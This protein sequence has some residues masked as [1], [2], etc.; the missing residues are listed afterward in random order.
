METFDEVAQ[1]PSGRA[2]RVVR[3]PARTGHRD[4]G[5][6]RNDVDS[7]HRNAR[8]PGRAKPRRRA[9]CGRSGLPRR[10]VHRGRVLHGPDRPDQL[11]RRQEDRATGQW[12]PRGRRAR[13]E[14]LRQPDERA[15]EPRTR[16]L[17]RR[18]HAAPDLDECGRVRARRRRVRRLSEDRHRHL[19]L[20]PGHQGRRRQDPRRAQPEL[21]RR[22][23]HRHDRARVRPGRLVQV[24]DIRVQ[25]RPGRIC[26]RHGGLRHRTGNRTAGRGRRDAGT[27][28]IRWR[29]QRTSA[30]SSLCA[31]RLGSADRPDRRRQPRDALVRRHHAQLPAGR[32]RAGIPRPVLDA[33][34]LCRQ[35]L[36]PDRG[37]PAGLEHRG[38]QGRR[39][40]RSRSCMAEVLVVRPRRRQQRH[41]LHPP[42]R[43]CRAHHRHRASGLAV[44][45]QRVRRIGD[46]APLRERHP[47]HAL[48]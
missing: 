18:R 2:R 10:P 27:S 8:D 20:D 31:V 11:Q 15:L 16:P 12:R 41:A 30:V 26:Q 34:H 32:H 5:P 35:P 48:R 9:L 42:G 29:R 23:R 45:R 24:P 17:Q 25:Q 40:W 28:R 21:Q 13:E 3:L 38:H 6:R 43:D 22:R 1:T 19:Q 33:G 4:A 47:G 14:P 44:P 36:L 46:Q 37:R 39:G 7:V